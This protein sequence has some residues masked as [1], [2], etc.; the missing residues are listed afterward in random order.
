MTTPLM[1][2][3]A[4]LSPQ[5]PPPVEQVYH[6][7]GDNGSLGLLF[8]LH[9]PNPRNRVG[10]I[11]V[12]LLDDSPTASPHDKAQARGLRHS[13]G[14]GTSGSTFV[15]QPHEGLWLGSLTVGGVLS[16]SACVSP[17]VGRLWRPWPSW[18]GRR[19]RPS[20]SLQSSTSSMRCD[21][22]PQPPQ[23]EGRHL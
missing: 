22:P 6:D 10:A 8:R 4:A 15:D 16:K 11:V 17:G 3:P 18:R 21:P 7:V 23:K 2:P 20:P 13:G 19:T 9:D 12:N 5:V 1:P 14:P